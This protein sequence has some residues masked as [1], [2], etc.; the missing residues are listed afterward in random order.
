MPAMQRVVMIGLGG[1]ALVAVL[2][3][4]Y[5]GRPP[6]PR[7]GVEASAPVAVAPG[8][9]AAPQAVSGA[10]AAVVAAGGAAAPRPAEAPRITAPETVTRA[11]AAPA[12]APGAGPAAAPQA[13][14]R[15]SAPAATALRAP[16][17]DV[18]RV[19]ATG[20]AVVA[21]RAA[22]GAEVV[23]LIDGGREIGSARADQRGEWV[24]LPP[25]IP[26]GAWELSLRARL[27]GQEAA[28]ADAVVVMVPEP[29]PQAA[30]T[31]PAAPGPFAVLLPEAAPPRLLQAPAPEAPPAP[32]LSIGSV[33]Q[34]GAGLRVAG[35]A[36]AGATVRVQ[37]G[38]R[39]TA[40]TTADA[41][42]RWQVAVPE[43]GTGTLRV[44]QLG[45]GGRVAARAEVPLEPAPPA[46]GGLGGRRVVVERGA[47]LWRIAREAY[48][49]GPR[50][51]VIYDA[52]RTQI[53]DP[54]LIFPG[55]VLELPGGE[56]R[57]AASSESR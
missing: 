55:Q 7:P 22:P 28:G 57:P 46:A 16:S 38:E 2:A 30:P 26:P 20:S 4:A 15:A 50:Y 48:G 53:R 42:G 45:A 6:A 10:P 39:Q 12:P 17:F 21:G 35:A 33:A 18:V 5:F 52:N 31:A 29:A 11:P 41:T 3:L 37:V 44:D 51:T 47:N 9:G 23:L 49:Q 14:G 40:E 36:P 25:R 19:G 43:A 8:P 13:P 34:E 56:A 32:G 1:V 27:N 24:I 54:S